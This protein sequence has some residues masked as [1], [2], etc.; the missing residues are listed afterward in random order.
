M[1][2]ECPEV[3]ITTALPASGGSAASGYTTEGEPVSKWK[4]KFANFAII[5]GDY[6]RAMGIPL[7][8]G[9]YFTPDD[10]PDSPSCRLS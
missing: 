1:S 2:P 3:G 7:I 9:R 10:G 8:E 6:F 4:L 5:Y